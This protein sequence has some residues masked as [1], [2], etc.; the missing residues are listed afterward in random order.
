M[1]YGM[2]LNDV[3]WE[4]TF[5][6]MTNPTISPDGTRT[7]AAVQVEDFSE[8]EIQKFQAGAYSAA[9]DGTPWDTKFVNVWNMAIS[10]DGQKLAAEVRLNLYDYTI[11]WVYLGAGV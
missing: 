3:S 4:G 7:A 11:A 8:G 1:K 5:T 10:P 6:N 9:V 2:A